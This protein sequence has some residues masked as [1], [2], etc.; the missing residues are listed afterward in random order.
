MDP[1][2][3]VNDDEMVE[4]WECIDSGVKINEDSVLNLH[5]EDGG[6]ADDTVG[7][8]V[9]GTEDFSFDEAKFCR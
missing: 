4:V 8:V 7:D 1:D 3:L 2:L 6:V 9:A 5:T